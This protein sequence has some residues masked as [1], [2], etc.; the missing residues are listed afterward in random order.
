MND[1]F[2]SAKD[3]WKNS[4][5]LDRIMLCFWLLGPWFFLI[6]RSPADA[7]ISLAGLL[8]L[9]RSGITGDWGWLRLGWVK[10]VGAFVLALVMSSLFSSL[11]ALAITESLIWMRFPLYAV[12]AAYWF[13]RSPGRLALMLISMALAAMVMSG[14]LLHEIWLNPHKIRLEGPYG[15]LVPGTFLGKSMLPLAV[16]TTVLALR[17]PFHQGVFIGLIPFGVLIMTLLTGERMNTGVMGMEIILAAML[18]HAGWHKV[19]SY[20]ALGI[21]GTVIIFLV[22]G[23]TVFIRTFVHTGNQVGDYFNSGYWGSVR[24]GVIAAM[25]YPWTGIGIGTFRYICPNLPDYAGVLPGI[26]G[27]HPHN[28]QF[29]IQMMAEGG[30]FSLITGVIMVIS[31]L[32]AARGKL[33]TDGWM[34]S[35]KP[36]VIPFVVLMPQTNADFFGQWHNCFM[37]FSIG[38][39]LALA[40]VMRRKGIATLS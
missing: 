6:E 33:V 2:T 3:A 9:I 17:A 30:I 28:H 5:G 23:D 21:I 19:L 14:I 10:A 12:A 35:I 7:W 4:H 38:F 24:P 26:S 11:A 39:A 37:W 20:A 13:G 15:D 16:V 27:C 8:F 36:W 32:L 22:K 1:I 25:E 29:Y 18:S 31:I 40:Q 34:Q